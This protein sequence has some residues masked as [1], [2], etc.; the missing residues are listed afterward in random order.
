MAI[1]Q[2]LWD[3]AKIMFEGGETLSKINQA[4]GIDIGSVSKNKVK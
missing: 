3:K 4:T 1:N 2:K